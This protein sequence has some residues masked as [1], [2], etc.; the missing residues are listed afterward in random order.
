MAR[1]LLTVAIALHLAGVAIACFGELRH[2]ASLARYGALFLLAGWTGE[3]ATLIVLGVMARAFPLRTGPEYLLVL[4][5]V[6]LTL[7]LDLW[8]RL[9][10]RAAALVLPPVAGLMVISAFL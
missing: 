3:L 2:R 4:G 8:F 5:W 7:H 6:V 1:A 9:R 10:V